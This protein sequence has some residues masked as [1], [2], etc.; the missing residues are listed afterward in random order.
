MF[1]FCHNYVEDC[2][3]VSNPYS[4]SNVYACTQLVVLCC[5][6]IVRQESK[7]G[8]YVSLSSFLGVSEKFLDLHY[9]KTKEAIYLRI[10]KTKKV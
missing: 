9:Q 7:G 1:P 5:V 2:A 3:A 10:K 6:D 8:L 4:S